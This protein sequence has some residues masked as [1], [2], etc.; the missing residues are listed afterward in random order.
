MRRLARPPKGIGP[1]YADKMLRSSAFRVGDLFDSTA[2]IE[3]LSRVVADRN[4][5]FAAMYGD[6]E[7]LDAGRIAE[8]C[9]RL[10]QRLA[11]HVTDTTA[12]LHEA[13]ASGKRILFEGAQGSMLDLDHGT[14]P[15]VT[16][17]TCTTGSIAAGAGVAPSTVTSYLGVMKAYATRVGGGPFPSELTDAM[18]DLIREKGHE[19]GTT[20][21]R[22]RRCGWLDAFA[23]KYAIGLS[24]VTHV[25]LM[26]VDTLVGFDEVRICTGYRYRGEV[27]RS[28]PS[29]PEV[30]AEVEPTYETLPG[31]SGAVAGVTSFEELPV[32]ARAY[33]GRLE[34]LLG[35]PISL[36]SVGPERGETLMNS[37]LRIM[38]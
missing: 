14:Y 25:A 30:F 28:F 6:E 16:S 27:L 10:G 1:C 33:V 18:G 3:R 32:E 34:E 37:R 35:V 24:G 9:L 26:H 17:S 5:F 2:F 38:D 31:W 29:R 21:G 4:R 15:F 19:Y 8:D 20:T 22:P 23:V 7:P 13:I 12:L 11:P 36:V